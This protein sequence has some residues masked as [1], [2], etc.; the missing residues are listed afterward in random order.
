MEW[1]FYV[2]HAELFATRVSCY[3]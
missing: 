3:Q 1:S 2:I